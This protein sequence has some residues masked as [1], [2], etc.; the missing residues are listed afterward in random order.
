MKVEFSRNKLDNDW[1]FSL[2]ISYQRTEFH[3]IYNKAFT[4]DLGFWTIYIRWNP[5]K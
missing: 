2:G 1:W 3:Y 4:V 5:N